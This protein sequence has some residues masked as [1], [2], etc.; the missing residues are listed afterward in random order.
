MY[1][2]IIS[3]RAEIQLKKIKQNYQDILSEVIDELKDDPFVGKALG[4]ELNGKFSY[5]I[6]VYRIIYRV[7]IQNKNVQIIS[8]G[9]RSLI[10]N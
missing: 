6:G 9:H 4:K 10:Y 2:I 8:A 1:K 7:N 5:K 3:P